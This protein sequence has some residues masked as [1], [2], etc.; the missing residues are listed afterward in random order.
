MVLAKCRFVYAPDELV[1][2][3]LL[4]IAQLRSVRFVSWSLRPARDLTFRSCFLR[5][6]VKAG[7]PLLARV[8]GA[9]RPGRRV[10]AGASMRALVLG[11]RR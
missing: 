1:L 8:V 7:W 9:A 5:P 11:R 3:A 4:R 2:K 6:G 10:A